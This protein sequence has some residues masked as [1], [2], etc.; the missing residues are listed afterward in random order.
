MEFKSLN[1]KYYKSIWLKK[2][3]VSELFISYGGEA[4]PWMLNRHVQQNE[5]FSLSEHL[6]AHA[7]K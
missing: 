2:G 3:P 5:M 1:E 6:L 4:F 7:W